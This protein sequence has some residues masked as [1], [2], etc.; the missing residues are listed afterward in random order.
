MGTVSLDEP[1]LFTP[2]PARRR[3]VDT[4]AVVLILTGWAG[5]VACAFWW[6]GVAGWAAVSLTVLTV[7]VL[8]GYER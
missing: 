5:I 4:A 3:W 7:G 8:L 6:D 2:P 1:P